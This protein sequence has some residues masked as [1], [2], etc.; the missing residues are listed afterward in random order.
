ML[1]KG[2]MFEVDMTNQ[3]LTIFLSLLFFIVFLMFI[4][5]LID[6]ALAEH[7]PINYLL[8]GGPLIVFL[9]ALT[10]ILILLGKLFLYLFNLF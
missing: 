1:I 3:F 5:H 2:V 8:T 7:K 4:C 6:S 10:G 9:G